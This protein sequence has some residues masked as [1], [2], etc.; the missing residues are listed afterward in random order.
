MRFVLKR[1]TL[2]VLLIV[3][4]A[5]ALLLSDLGRRTA[6]AHSV[7]HVALLQHASTMLLDEGTR[8]AIDGL[9]EHG[10][11]D[12]KT[13]VM[14]Q[15]NAHGDIAV[16]NSI[17]VEMVQARYDLLLTMS[18]L[19]LQAVANANRGGKTVQVFG[20]VADPAVAGVGISWENPLAHPRNLVGLGSFLPVQEAFA[21][22][23]QMFPELK[24]VGA[25]WNPAEANSR[26]YVESAREACQRMGIELLEANV[27]N[28]NSVLEAE[29]SLVARGAEVLWI[30]GD[31][32]VSV[33]AESVVAVGRR[34]RIPVFSITP[35]KPDRGT[36][37]DYGA[38]FYQI[39]RQTGALAA[40][41]L[42]GADVAKIPIKNAI[43][44]SFVVNT[45]ALKGLRQA[46]RV[47]P[48]ILQRANIVVDD[49]GIHERAVSG[50][51]AGAK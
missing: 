17:A 39:G 46:W 6:K 30:G 40:E 36:L 33:A 1:L 31:V 13:I 20:L 42:R 51:A 23:R 29:E 50:K 10:F 32:T 35:G 21:I 26:A 11:V 43:P 15:F 18:T 9:A 38:D 4:A 5:G 45:T 34:A 24:R 48:G 37:F 16:G 27:E 44:V 28:S 19:S 22:A 41:V 25:A 8:G 3:S 14:D 7:P 12:G 49:A 2:G 47:P